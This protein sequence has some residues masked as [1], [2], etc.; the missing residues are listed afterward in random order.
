MFN[1]MAHVPELMIVCQIFRQSSK[2]SARRNT[3]DGVD[4]RIRMALGSAEVVEGNLRRLSNK[5]DI[6][7]LPT[8]RKAEV[9]KAFERLVKILCRGDCRVDR[10]ACRYND[11]S[12]NALLVL[13]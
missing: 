1:Q 2:A 10:H 4:L 7:A 9:H 3:A 11:F 8:P 5:S 13:V 6:P 12:L